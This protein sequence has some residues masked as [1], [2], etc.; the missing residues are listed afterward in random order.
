M[1]SEQPASPGRPV[2]NP[3]DHK[4][5][6]SVAGKV[7]EATAAPPQS[8]QP[9][10]A[11]AIPSEAI[12]DAV[13][14]LL[15]KLGEEEPKP[16]RLKKFLAHPMTIVMVTFMFSV[17][18]GGYLT[19]SYTL[20]QQELARQ[21]SFTDELNKIR[22]QKIGEVWEE[23]DRTE[24]ELDALLDRANKSPDAGG[25]NVDNII[26]LVEGEVATVNKNRFWLGDQNYDRIKNYLDINGRYAL[27]KL[28]GRQD[29]DL[30]ETVRKREQAKDDVLQIR[31]RFQR[32]ELEP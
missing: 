23:I 29:I 24:L 13:L 27:D 14:G 21:R 3:P 17:L 12:A 2:L 7:A 1:K 19:N 28:L 9:T 25:K 30:T 26:K 11:P 31:R 18:L 4:Q 5:N 20:G 32:G 8:V 6:E 15:R 16:P 10:G 22:V